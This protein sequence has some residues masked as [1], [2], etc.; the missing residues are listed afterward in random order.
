V[1]QAILIDMAAATMVAVERMGPAIRAALDAHSPSE[2]PQFVAELRA[3]LADAGQDLDLAGR[4][5]RPC[6]AA[7]AP[8]R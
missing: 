6:C 4:G 2:E 8:A 5:R 3:A 1:R 7:G